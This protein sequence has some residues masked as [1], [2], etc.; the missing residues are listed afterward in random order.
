VNVILPVSVALLVII[1]IVVPQVKRVLSGKKVVVSHLLRE[2]TTLP[3]FGVSPGTHP[4]AEEPS[5]CEEGNATSGDHKGMAE[6]SKLVMKQDDP[7]PVEV[8]TEMYKLDEIIGSLKEKWYVD[9]RMWLV[10]LS[11]RTFQIKP[12]TA[13]D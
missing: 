11:P 13:I 12:H 5:G 7:L 1:Y 9:C 6:V 4:T 10:L 3:G 8:E 2:M